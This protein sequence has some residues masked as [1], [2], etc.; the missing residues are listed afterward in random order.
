VVQ[1]TGPA[2]QPAP[3]HRGRG[4]APA[5]GPP[6]PRQQVGHDR[7]ALP[8][9]DRQ[10]GEE[11]LARRHGTEVPRAEPI[12]RASQAA[13]PASDD[14]FVG[15][16]MRPG[17]LCTGAQWVP[18]LVNP[19]AGVH[20]Q[21]LASSCRAE[22]QGHSEMS[23]PPF[24]QFSDGRATLPDLGRTEQGDKSTA[25]CAERSS[26]APFIDFLGVGVV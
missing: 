24:P 13:S 2:H 5:R 9:P 1:S 17:G 8:R 12:L 4:G 3:V 16:K 7:A 15:L 6:L 11:P 10:R 18:S 20:N 23:F 26:P 19:F 22:L 14:S 21:S 25:S